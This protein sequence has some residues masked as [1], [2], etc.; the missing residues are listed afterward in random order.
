MSEYQ[1]IFML[2]SYPNNNK[3]GI[4]ICKNDISEKNILLLQK[5]FETTI[6]LILFMFQQKILIFLILN[7]DN[8]FCPL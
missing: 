8:Y 4:I 3:S 2:F 1:R 6:L 5:F 7:R